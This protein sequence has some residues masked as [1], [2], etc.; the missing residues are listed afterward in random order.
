[1]SGDTRMSRLSVLSKAIKWCMRFLFSAKSERV[2]YAKG[3][4]DGV[5]QE[6]S[7]LDEFLDPN[8]T[9]IIK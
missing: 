8:E 4:E 1:M 5:K 7:K 9:L 3:F 2:A 6:Q